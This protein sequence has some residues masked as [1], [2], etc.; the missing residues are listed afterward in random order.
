MDL[1]QTY[2]TEEEWEFLGPDEVINR[3]EDIV[4]DSRI[5]K[6]SEPT[7]SP[8]EQLALR[9]FHELWKDYCWSTPRVM[10]PIEVLKES[11]KWQSLREQAA[12]TLALFSERG[13]FEE[14][15]GAG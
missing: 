8:D 5:S 13:R 7:F 10:P 1:L 4:D 11:S 9:K 3:W 15:H 6:Y 14:E 12:T 2:S